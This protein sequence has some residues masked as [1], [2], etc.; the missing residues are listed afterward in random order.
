MELTQEK[1]TCPCCLL[2][3]LTHANKALIHH[4]QS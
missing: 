1:M 4:I 2:E 3:I